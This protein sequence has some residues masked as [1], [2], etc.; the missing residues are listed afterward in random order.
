MATQPLPFEYAQ[1]WPFLKEFF[2]EPLSDELVEQMDQRDRD[3]E[4]FLVSVGG[5]LGIIDHGDGLVLTGFTKSIHALKPANLAL[6]GGSLDVAGATSTVAK[7]F[8]N[9]LDTGLT[10]TIPAGAIFAY[11]TANLGFALTDRWQ[12][13]VTSAGTGA[14]GLS[15]YGAYR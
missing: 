7:I 13:Q 5:V 11:I 8:K 10:L 9:S 12:M 14:Q 15:F 1:R 6:V 4:D 3:L 2:P